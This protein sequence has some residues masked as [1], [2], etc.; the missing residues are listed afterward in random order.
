ML[1]LPPMRSP[2]ALLLLAASALAAPDAR[3]EFLAKQLR[4]SNDPRL[5]VQA[6]VSL[7]ALGL[8]AVIDPLCT[9]LKDPEPIVRA[10]AAKALGEMADPNALPCLKA[11]KGDPDGSVDLAVAKAIELLQKPKALYISLEPVVV[12]S[13]PLSPSDAALADELIRAELAKLGATFAPTGEAAAAAQLVIRQKKMKGFLLKPKLKAADSSVE[14]KLLVLTYP[15]K[16]LK[17]T[18]KITARGAKGPAA[19]RALVP[20]V[21]KQAADDYEWKQ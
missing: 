2:I 18:N 17:G 3:V 21:V 14:L 5:R 7:G 19:I 6:A 8:P 15:E 9:A 16:E 11:R 13:G 10:A 4:T 1:R 20:A 12:E